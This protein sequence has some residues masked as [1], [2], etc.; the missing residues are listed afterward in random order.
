MKPLGLSAS[1]GLDRDKSPPGQNEATTS[2]EPGMSPGKAPLQSQIEINYGGPE[3]IQQSQ[4]PSDPAVT[5][6][7][8]GHETRRDEEE[9]AQLGPTSTVS[10]NIIS[11][12]YILG[13]SAS[14]AG[15]NSIQSSSPAP[16]THQIAQANNSFVDPSVINDAPLLNKR[17]AFLFR[18]YI[19]K[20]APSVSQDIDGTYHYMVD[21][22]ISV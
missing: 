9:T 5:S 12:P 15:P 19:E 21:T 11:I 2:K 22:K 7:A 10:L 1:D 3:F 8:A 13:D 16:T 6:P 20:L 14:S 18:T 17:E 4:T